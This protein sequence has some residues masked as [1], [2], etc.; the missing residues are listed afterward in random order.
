[1]GEG[2]GVVHS[3]NDSG[4]MTPT[5]AHQKQI[6]QIELTNKASSIWSLS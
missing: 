2:G 6:R 4:V 5:Y 1:M 3:T